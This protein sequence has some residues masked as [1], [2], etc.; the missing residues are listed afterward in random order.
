M[1][2]RADATGGE[3]L[4]GDIEVMLD[5]AV[6][7]MVPVHE[8][9]W[10]SY[11]HERPYP[12]VT[13]DSPR[14]MRLVA[15]EFAIYFKRETPFDGYPYSASRGANARPQSVV[16]IPYRSWV[17]SPHCAVAGAVGVIPAGSGFFRKESDH[18][19]AVTWM[20]LHPHARGRGLMRG[21]WEFIRKQWPTA[22]MTGPFTPAGARLRKA[23][24]GKDTPASGI[25]RR[26]Y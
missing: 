19:S 4:G 7:R 11:D 3:P 5:T 12:V 22:T 15:E 13:D 23:L 6:I 1:Y 10:S 2:E 8:R 26:N 21:A 16:L 25:V 17:D 24:E 14:E 18:L 20:W 9:F